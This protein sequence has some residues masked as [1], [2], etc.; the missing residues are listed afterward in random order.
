VSEAEAT[1]LPG[2]FATRRVDKPWGHELIWALTDK[3]CG[4]IIV[5]ETGRRLSLQYH[6]QKDEAIYVTSG[7]LLLHIDDDAGALTTRELGPGDAAHIAVGR[8]HRYEAI[9]RVE[10]VEVSTPELL[11]VVRVEDDFGREGT[12]NP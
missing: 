4:K 6:E 5:I 1:V 8:R 3:Y 9:E 10:L 2:A 11:D 7:R 12:S